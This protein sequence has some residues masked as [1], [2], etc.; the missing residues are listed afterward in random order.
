MENYLTE[1][2]KFWA[3][4]F[5]VD[6]IERN[7]SEQLNASN[8]FFFSNILKNTKSIDSVL[9]IGAN[10]GMNL[11]ALNQLLPEAELSGIEINNKAYEILEKNI[12]GKAYL[13]SILNF[14]VDYQ[15]DLVL[16]K[17]VLIHLN[18]EYL[19]KVYDL[20]Y[21]ASKKYIIIAEYYNPSP[22]TIKYRGEEDKLFK[23]DF[24]GELLIKFNDLE[25]ID[26]G[27]AYH[28]DKKFP[29]DDITWFLLKKGE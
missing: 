2:E 9:E 25:L 13:E 19:N 20:L 6:Y 11:R 29:Q 18:P 16:S 5:G 3:G 24:A 23:R 14:S 8:L 26:Y 12:N 4:K 22:V 28:K 27:F 17:G 15:R 21:T 10:I 1:Q 7:K